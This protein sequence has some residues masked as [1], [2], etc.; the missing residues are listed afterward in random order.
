MPFSR[1]GARS[2]QKEQIFQVAF[3]YTS[4]LRIGAGGGVD[5]LLKDM[6]PF[7]GLESNNLNGCGVLFIDV[8]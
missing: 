4:L 2:W 1:G 7:G 6:L 3:T 5:K 8:T